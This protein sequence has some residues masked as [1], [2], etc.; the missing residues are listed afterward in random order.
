M[1]SRLEFI[2]QDS[3]HHN[4]EGFIRNGLQCTAII[5]DNY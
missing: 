3:I 1:T 2:M 4:Q 5:T